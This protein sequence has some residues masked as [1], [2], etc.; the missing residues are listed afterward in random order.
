MQATEQ[1]SFFNPVQPPPQTFH[2]LPDH[3]WVLAP[4]EFRCAGMAT[5]PGKREERTF[6]LLFLGEL[7]RLSLDSDGTR[8]SC[9]WN[10]EVYDVGLMVHWINRWNET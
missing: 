10:A 2:L 5:G 6:P 1:V 3:Q 4:V 7:Q 8:Q 9:F